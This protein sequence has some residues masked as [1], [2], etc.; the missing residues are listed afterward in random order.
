M[1]IRKILVECKGIGEG[2]QIL[3]TATYK[4]ASNS[5]IVVTFSTANIILGTF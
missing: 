1:K 2:K 5:Y 4:L 3:T